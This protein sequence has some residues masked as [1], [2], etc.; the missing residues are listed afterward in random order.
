MRFR[1]A[2]LHLLPHVASGRRDILPVGQ[3]ISMRT[4]LADHALHERAL[5]DTRAEEDS[6]DQQ[7]N[8]ATLREEDC[9]AKEAEPERDLKTGNNRHAGVIVV[10][11]EAANAVAESGCLRLLAGWS[12]RWWLDGGE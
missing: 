10:F 1:S 11:D 8:P 2:A 3:S 4:H 6:V 12:W 5:G 9:G 7:E